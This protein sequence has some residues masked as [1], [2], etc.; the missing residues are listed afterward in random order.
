MSFFSKRKPSLEESKQAFFTCI[1]EGRVWHHRKKPRAHLFDYNVAMVYLDLS[2]LETVL[3]LS[4]LWGCSKLHPASFQRRHYFGNER[5]SISEAVLEEIERELSIRPSGSV[6]LLTNLS[7]FG[8][9]TNPI[10]C[11]YVFDGSGDDELLVALLLEVTNTPWGESCSYVLDMRSGSMSERSKVCPSVTFDKTMHVSPFMPMDMFYR[12]SGS[13]P[14][15]KLSYRLGNYRYLETEGESG[16]LTAGPVTSR[17]HAPA[18]HWFS[19]GVSF[20]RVPMT[21][22]N[23]RRLV[24]R[25]PLMTAQVLAGIYWQALRLAFKRVGFYKHPNSVGRDMSSEE[26]AGEVREALDEF[27]AVAVD[28]S[29]R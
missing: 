7:Y 11:Y 20:D 5:Q 21:A 15:E 9:I 4:R 6:R 28:Q 22:R 1:Y 2:E 3:G 26:N 8:Y 25:Y 24:W 10:S 16:G 23:M 29:A 18:E 14:G 13:L 17:E 12:W 27:N 19:A